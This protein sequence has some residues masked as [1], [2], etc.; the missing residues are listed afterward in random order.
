MRVV[1]HDG[2]AGLGNRGDIVEVADGYA[3]NLLIPKGLAQRASSGV[4]AQASVM[5]RAWQV[6]NAR[7]REAAEEVA[8]VLVAKTIEISARAGSEGKLFGSV[9]SND[10]ASAVRDQA[11]IELDRKMIELDEPIRS[12]GTHAVMVKPHN[13]VHFPV[14]ILVV[15]T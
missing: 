9:T 15:Q 3:R 12:L 13:E 4:E 6:R 7:Q 11:G 8:K 1:L 10:I 14:S 5:K 2:I